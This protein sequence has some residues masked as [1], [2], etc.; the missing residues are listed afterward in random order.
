V[1]RVAVVIPAL[2]EA[3]AVGPVVAGALAH[4]ATWVIV[5]DNGSA[6]AT[7][8]VAAAAGALV[9]S[10]PR[11]GYGYA[12]ACGFARALELGADIIVTMDGDGSALGD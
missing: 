6:D 3:G 1:K 4:A 12:C 7:A 2:N 5:V 8:E 9:L 10:E 11:R